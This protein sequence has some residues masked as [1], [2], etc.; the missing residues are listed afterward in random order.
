MKRLSIADF[1]FPIGT[2]AVIAMVLALGLLAA[3]L[4]ADGQQPAKVY[5]IGWLGFD[6]APTNAT[7]HKCPING[8][9]RWQAWVEGLRERGYV[10]GQNLI[11]EC[12]WTEGRPERAAPLAIELV[13]LKVDLILANGSASVLATKQATSAIPIVMVGVLSPV[14]RGLVASLARPG[15]NVTGLTNS[16][17]PQIAGKYLQLLKEAV[18]G[19][20]RVAT[21]AYRANPMEPPYRF[22]DELHAAAQALGV[23]LHSIEVEGPDGLDHAFAMVAKAQADALLVR[24]HPFFLDA[25]R[26]VDFAAKHRLPAMYPFKEA[27]E[28]GGLMAYETDQPDIFQRLGV[29]VDKI[30]KGAKPGDLPVE[31]PTKF[32]LIINLNTA[33]A[34]GI[35]IPK[36]VLL[37]AD[38]VIQ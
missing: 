20:S 16:A 36:D 11:I 30:F 12:R 15:G 19:I 7:P 5:R 33:K 9:S 8:N 29:Y 17:G 2:P 25:R 22:T 21:L 35:T 13:S 4:P 28:A 24:P 18:P 23:T 26:I 6:P 31:Q 10:E 32:D 38:E 27:V 3:P 1:R 37:R 34:L 14:E